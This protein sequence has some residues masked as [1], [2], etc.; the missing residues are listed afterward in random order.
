MSKR[1]A[2]V[3]IADML[4]AAT[5]ADNYCRGVDYDNFLTDQKTIDAVLR[6]LAVLGEAAKKVPDD[7]RQMYP[8]IEW[9]KISRSRN[10]IVHDYFAID[11]QIVW[12]IVKE[13]L[14]GLIN[15]LSGV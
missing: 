3:L 8:N 15:D 2:E 1:I 4:E 11:H 10:I 9:E 6:N 5:R 12:K 14:P 13:Y 7:V